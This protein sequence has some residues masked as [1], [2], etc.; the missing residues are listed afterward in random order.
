ME[1]ELDSVEATR[2]LGAEL[3][4]M[5]GPGTVIALNGDLGAGKTEFARGFV[6][7]LPEC[8][9]AEI[10]SP[11]FA[12]V[13]RYETSPPVWHL[14]LYRLENEAELA[15]IGGEEFFDPIDEITL[16]E[17]AERFPNWLP[18]SAWLVKLERTGETTRRALLT[19][20]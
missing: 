13:H 8:N 10:A 19:I 17:W 15:A 4:Q 7:A 11:T 1:R 5:A 14:D 6:A 18:A 16:V 12:L 9:A 20:P 3:A 2:R